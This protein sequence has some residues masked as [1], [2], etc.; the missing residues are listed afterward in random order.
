MT[1]KTRS[2]PGF[3]GER[4]TVDVYLTKHRPQNQQTVGRGF[5]INP[6]LRDDFRNTA[7]EYRE[8]L[9]KEDWEGLPYIETY[10][11]EQAEAHDRET[12]ASHRAEGNE[13]VISDEELNAKLDSRKAHFFKL[14]PEGK[15]YNVNCLDGGAWDRPTDWGT[16]PTLEE[17]I[18]CCELGPVWRRSKSQV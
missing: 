7:N 11:W 2:I 1:K 15:L 16:F 3:D 14:Y 17:A 5:P 8:P 13:F 9:E 18:E 6:T 10:T 4:T 12:Q